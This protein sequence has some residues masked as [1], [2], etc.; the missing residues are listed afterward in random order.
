MQSELNRTGVDAEFLAA[1]DGRRFP[2]LCKGKSGLLSKEEVALV[3]SHRRAWRKLLASPASCAVVLEDDVH[4]GA[5]IREFLEVDFSQYS[6]H[7]IKLEMWSSRVW[8]SR[9]AQP[10]CGRKLHRLGHEHF[11]AAA[12]VISRA[13][14]KKL[15]A[16]TRP[17]FEP[18]DV[19]LF[20]RRAIVNNELKVL[21][22]VPAI[23]IQDSSL[24]QAA[25][26]RNFDSILHEDR[27]RIKAA[28]RLNKPR[29]LLRLKK[30]A[31]RISDQMR[32]WITLL[33]T[34]RCATISWE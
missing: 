26:K 32:R 2:T 9:K 16:A 10:A 34:M 6:F 18:V 4:F 30:E 8:I 14:A 7:A 28:I 31:L 13:G 12:Y 3:I 5:N 1:A 19:T 20:G 29:G 22:L 25:A 21:Q 17:I 15:L 11:G 33:P 27:A 23:A 24:P